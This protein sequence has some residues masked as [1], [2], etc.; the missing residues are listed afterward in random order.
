MATGK[1]ISNYKHGEYKTR[2][3][4]IWNAM[5][6][7]TLHVKNE[8]SIYYKNYKGRGITVCDEWRDYKV[9]AEWA[10]S[11]GYADDLTLDRIDNSGNYCPENCRWATRKEQANNTRKN[12]YI[13]YNGETHTM[14]EW[15]DITG[16]S[17]STLEKR[18]ERGEDVSILFRS[19]DRG[20]PVIST[21][22]K[23]NEMQFKSAYAAAK[24]FGTTCNNVARV[25]KGQRGSWHGY[26]FRYVEERVA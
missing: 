4:K 1:D 24:Y 16:L 10:R 12:A 20:T 2:L 13:T 9:F 11:H 6:N 19:P 7:R 5:L 25:C 3:Y 22:L 18:Y 17:Y 21:D 23:G 26:R 15:S 8:D 14:S